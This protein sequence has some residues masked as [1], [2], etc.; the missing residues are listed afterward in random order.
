MWD[1]SSWLLSFSMVSLRLI[2]VSVTSFFLWLKKIPLQHF[3][4][5]WGGG[6]GGSARPHFP[7]EQ[8]SLWN[9]VGGCGHM[10]KKLKDGKREWKEGKEEVGRKG[11]HI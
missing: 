10:R 6:V 7:F 11:D 9:Q 3:S 4:S 8:S 5:K 2:H 1:L